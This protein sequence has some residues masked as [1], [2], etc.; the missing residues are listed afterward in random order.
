MPSVKDN[1]N[2]VKAVVKTDLLIPFL[3]Y[4]IF[5][6]A[7]GCIVYL[8][9]M[10]ND[11]VNHVDGI[12]HPSHFIAGDWEISLGR[13]LQRYA[14]R[15]RFGLVTSSWNSVL[16]IVLVG[17]ADCMLIERFRLKD[18]FFSYLFVF[19]T[20]ANP[21]VCESLTY[22][23]MSLNFALAYFFSVLAF[24]FMSG[25]GKT[26][27][28]II[29]DL[30]PAIIAFALSMAFYQAY[31]CVFA[32][33][34]VF[35]IIAF[36]DEESDIKPIGTEIVKVL[37]TFVLGGA[38]YMLI[39]KLLLFRAGVEMASYRGADDISL[40]G[41]IANLPA[42]IIQAVKETATYIYINKLQTAGLEFSVIVV[43]CLSIACAIVAVME[44]IDCFKRKKA[45]AFLFIVMIILLP[46]AA[47]VI[48]LI[49][50]G[51]GISGLMAMG[52]L[53]SI[54]MFYTIAGKKNWTKIMLNAC[55]ILFAWYLVSAIE[56]DQIAL[57]EGITATK[58]IANNAYK[59]ACSEYTE[60]EYDS[61]AFVGRTAENP[62]FYISPVYDMANGY[63]QFGRWSTG[64]RNNRV[65]WIGVMNMLC[66]S[67]ID[68]CDEEAYRNI[69]EGDEIKNMP[70]YPQKGYIKLID[71]VLVIKISDCY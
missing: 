26:K 40:I 15:A 51:S 31:I 45:A 12:W 16:Y 57:K 11:L 61:I 60:E 2:D 20:V 8:S 25:R 32:V 21:V 63:A 6:V 55:L 27:N 58:T 9:L 37:I 48:C 14:D 42:G 62:L 54:P 23:Y 68:F 70:V 3:K 13:G 66:G 71:D 56:T 24:F 29:K 33:L 10:S 44:F 22:S 19:I 59:E 49:A 5:A 69:V 52:I 43:I 65:T 38:L 4:L 35:W 36:I 53:I 1:Q 41:I 17:F 47:S 34:S 67:E 39:T 50:V 7:A 30:V 18:T 64:S 28:E 46:I